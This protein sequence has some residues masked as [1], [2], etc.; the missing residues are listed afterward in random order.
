ML[1]LFGMHKNGI[2]NTTV[3]KAIGGAVVV[4]MSWEGSKH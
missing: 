4:R 3:A 2:G 1:S